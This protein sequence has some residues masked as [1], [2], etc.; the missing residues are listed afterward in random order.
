M[1][2]LTT[3]PPTRIRSVSMPST[4]TASSCLP[5]SRL[6]IVSCAIERRRGVDRGADQRLFERHVHAEAGERHHE[7]HRRREAAAG[8]RSVASATA[9]PLLDQHP[10]RREAAELQEERRRRQQRGDD[11]RLAPAAG[12]AVRRRRSGDRPSARRPRRRP[13]DPPLSASSSAWMRGFSPCRRP[14]SRMSRDSSGVNTPC[15]QNTS[16]HS[17]SPSRGDRRDHLVDRPGARRRARS[18][19]N[20]TGTSCAP[21]KVAV[22][23]IGWPAASVRI[24][25]SILQFRREAE[26]VAALRFRGRRAV[27]QHLREPLAARRRP[28]RPRWRRASRPRS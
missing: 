26:A 20:S 1:T 9:T 23:S 3:G 18:C 25:R 17:A 12:R 27:R 28:A 6:P 11:A 16:H 2:C 14:A 8:L 24:A 5:A 19:R 22:S 13:R 15:S 4:I 7:R 10:R 21:M